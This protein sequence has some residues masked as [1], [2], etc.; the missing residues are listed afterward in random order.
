MP[1]LCGHGRA[2]NVGSSQSSIAA[3]DRT[4][5]RLVPAKGP[6]SL[7][8]VLTDSAMSAADDEQLFTT[9]IAWK[10]E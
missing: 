6:H 3:V 7:R 10:I 4:V 1:P 9:G 8:G 2:P 5:A